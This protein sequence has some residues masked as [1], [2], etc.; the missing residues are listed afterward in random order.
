MPTS[1]AAKNAR[2]SLMIFSRRFVSFCLSLSNC[3]T[4]RSSDVHDEL[5]KDFRSSGFSLTRNSCS[6]AL[7]GSSLD[8]ELRSI[9]AV[10]DFRGPSLF[11]C[12]CNNRLESPAVRKLWPRRCQCGSAS[13]YLA[14]QLI[15]VRYCLKNVSYVETSYSVCKR[16]TKVFSAFRDRRCFVFQKFNLLRYV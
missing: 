3:S 9:G 8:I 7:N 16:L 15:K 5:S 12:R 1:T 2:K 14:V 13:L 6:A 4:R 11:I 10:C